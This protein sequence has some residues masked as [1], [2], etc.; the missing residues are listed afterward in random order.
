[1]LDPVSRSL[2]SRAQNALDLL[3]KPAHLG[4]SGRELGEYSLFRVIQSLRRIGGDL[5]KDAPFEAE[6]SDEIAKRLGRDTGFF[7]P[8]DKLTVPLGA[9]A[10]STS[11]GAKGGYLVGVENMGFID[12]LRARSVATSMGAQVLGGLQ[13]NVTFAR[14]TGKASISWQAGDG[15]GVAATDQT[16]GQISMT[17]KTCIAITDVS[18]QL[19][20]Q[21]RDAESLLL[22]DLAE[23]VA[24]DG[25][26]RAVISGAGGSEP[27]GI[28]NMPGITTA[29][30]A[31]A[32]TYAKVLAF[33]QV[34]AS[35]N[36]IKTAPG[37]VTNATG[38][39]ALMQRQ[40]FTGTDTP[41]WE[42]NPLD[43]TL[44]GFR[45]MSSEQLGAG[46]L[47][48]GSWG[49]IVIGEWGVLEL[50]V[51][52]G[53]TRFDNGMVGLRAMWMVDVMFRYPQAFVVSSN[54]S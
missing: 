19:L 3:A 35:A 31:A 28:R 22:R 20:R 10:M 11:S 7:V 44:A 9:R 34:A 51:D 38:A 24:T 15:A 52:R 42:G 25:V 14:Q 26:D 6:A 36:A 45:A 18:E 2:V 17:P 29:Q 43:G 46:D 8:S 5:R 13:G 39:I 54:L 53:G 40:R 21:G 4:L 23:S 41:L 16:L 37:W 48:F 27:L 1:M 49:E 50:D 47:I 33:P 30:D 12:V 32:A